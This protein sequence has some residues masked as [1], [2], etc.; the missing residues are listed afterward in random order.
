MQIHKNE[1]TTGLIV[2]LTL[3]LLVT[4]LV[5]IGLPG[6]I[7][8]LN[9]YRIYF[10]NAEGIRPGAPVLLAGREIGKVKSLKSPVPM[11]ERP[12]GH[13]EDEVSILIEVNR[14][15][16]IYRQVTVLLTQQGLMGQQIIDFRQGDSASELAPDH[17]EFVGQRVPDITEA[18][19]DN[20]KRLTGD[21][22]DLALTLKNIHSITDKMNSVDLSKTMGN[23][24]E[25]TDTLKRQPWR[26]LWP[27]TKEYPGD[28]K[29]KE[30]K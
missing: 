22:S 1:A 23:V 26:L 14:S 11:S 5:V 16:R 8:P 25:L 7:R 17:M 2:V 28:P 9:T 30:K 29:A 24:Q 10:D 6:I 12:N 21:G 27:A 19:A 18:V 3:G 20:M 13:P 4:I 15:A